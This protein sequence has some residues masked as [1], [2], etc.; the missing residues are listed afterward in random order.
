[1]VPK[2]HKLFFKK[3]FKVETDLVKKLP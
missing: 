1:V 2:I 3:L